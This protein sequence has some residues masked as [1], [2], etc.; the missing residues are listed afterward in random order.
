MKPRDTKPH[1][2]DK[3]SPTGFLRPLFFIALTTCLIFN[4]QFSIVKA[5]QVTLAR[6]D[7]PR[8]VV[9]TLPTDRPEVRLVTFSD[10]TFRYISADPLGFRAAPAY[11]SRWDTV[12]LFSSRSVQQADLPET[13]NM[14]MA[15]S[16]GFHAP[17]V[18]RVLSKYGPRGRR[19]H[20][21][22]DI[23]LEHGQPVFAA[24]DGIVRLSRWN[25][26]GF[27]NIVI[28]RHPN[29]L[30]T[31]YG[32]LSRRAVVADDWVRAGQVIGYGGR[33][34]RASTNHLHFETRYADQ[35]FDA[36]RLFD[37]ERGTLRQRNF[38]LRKEY[39]NINSRAS[40]GL[41]GETD[42]QASDE[43]L[44]AANPPIAQTGS[45]ATASGSESQKSES[46]APAKPSEPAKPKQVYHKI[47]SGDTLLALAMD[48]HTTVAD[49]CALNNITRTS[50][51]RIGR[52]LRIK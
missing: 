7:I 39:F 28:I 38:A 50:T 31:Y 33:T 51:L 30:E 27:G 15:E 18:G 22:T 12:N 8:S 21:G 4:P 17:V 26:G 40:E 14:E 19:S 5:Q 24:F 9:D 45:S 42:D 25:S 43:A 35:S 23:R 48:Y 49:I 37:F 16:H 34:G 52:N 2:A 36:E 41:D 13:I 47:K 46:P 11:E 29:G 1:F 20:N 32:H 44:L 3:H 10:G 6:K